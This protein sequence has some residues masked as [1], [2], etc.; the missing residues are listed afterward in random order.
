MDYKIW[1]KWYQ[2]SL[3]NVE[4]ENM[5][6][7]SSIDGGRDIPVMYAPSF[8]NISNVPDRHFKK[9]FDGKKEITNKKLL[10]RI[11]HIRDLRY[12]LLRSKPPIFNLNEQLTNLF[13]RTSNKVYLRELPFDCLFINADFG[14]GFKGLLIHK[15]DNPEKDILVHMRREDE[16]GQGYFTELSFSQTKIK[17]YEH[18]FTGIGYGNID[19]LEVTK[20]LKEIYPSQ[21]KLVL[22]VCNFLDALNHPDIEIIE[23]RNDLNND[24]S[25]IKRG[26]SPKPSLQVNINVK[27]KLYKYLNYEQKKVNNPMNYSFW[28]R[29]HYIH[30]WNQKRWCKLYSLDDEQLSKQGYQKDKRGV[31]AKW[32]FPFIKCEGISKPIQKDYILKQKKETIS[33]IVVINDNSQ[34][35]LKEPIKQSVVEDRN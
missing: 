10:K 25:R 31:I 9:H 30:F 17:K 20:E 11:I 5:I 29:G 18:E 16:N 4:S 7:N 35:N 24:E 12:E 1:N 2:I 13:L 21:K 8:L 28:V 34:S 15:Q 26:K 23:I 33:N 19:M 27:G 22:F 14:D 6:L 3:Q 32:K